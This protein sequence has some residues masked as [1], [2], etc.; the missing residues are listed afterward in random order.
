M[1]KTVY[2][3]D[4]LTSQDIDIV[5]QLGVQRWPNFEDWCNRNKVNY[6]LQF[7]PDLNLKAMSDKEMVAMALCDDRFKCIYLDVLTVK[8]G[9]RK[10]GIGTG[11]IQ[12][13]E[14]IGTQKGLRSIYLESGDR[15]YYT[16][17]EKFYKVRGFHD[18]GLMNIH[19][20]T[21]HMMEKFL[22]AMDEVVPEQEYTVDQ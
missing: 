18:A 9:F 17:A 3:I 7:N 20:E 11:F 14:K 16:G 13:L 22:P 4:K 10:Q 12:E 19:K 1:A 2:P 6:M 21:I 15:D 5:M 8:D